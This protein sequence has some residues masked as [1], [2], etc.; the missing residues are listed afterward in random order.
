MP[1]QPPTEAYCVDIEH[2]VPTFVAV[3]IGPADPVTGDRT[4][5]WAPG[6]PSCSMVHTCYPASSG[7]PAVPP[8]P[9]V[10]GSPGTPGTPGSPANYLAGWTG[11]ARSVQ[12]FVGNCYYTF[13]V[14]YTVT[15]VVTGLNTRDDNAGFLEIP[16]GFRIQ[17]NTWA[18]IEHGQEKTNPKSRD[19]SGTTF[20][21]MQAGSHTYY[22]V[23]GAVVYTGDKVGD[24]DVFADASLFMGGDSITD[25]AFS[26]VLDVTLLGVTGGNDGVLP[27]NAGSFNRD[28]SKEGVLSNIVGFAVGGGANPGDAFQAIGYLSQLYTENWVDSFLPGLVGSFA[29]SNVPVVSVGILTGLVNFNER[30]VALLPRLIGYAEGNYKMPEYGINDVVLPSVVGFAYATGGNAG[31]HAGKLSKL[32][33]FATD[34]G[35]AF[36]EGVLT[37]AH[38]GFIIAEFNSNPGVLRNLVSNFNS[39]GDGDHA[40]RPTGTF[41][42]LWSME[43]TLAISRR[44]TGTFTWEPVVHVNFNPV[45]RI[46]GTMRGAETA[47]SYVAVQRRVSGSMAGAWGV[48]VSPEVVRPVRGHMHGQWGASCAVVR[49]ISLSGVFVSGETM[50]VK[51]KLK[52]K[53]VVADDEIVVYSPA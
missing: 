27:A 4:I 34:Q 3:F 14:P 22:V 29:L 33:G 38:D 48:S 1:A 49:H 19:F 44:M 2:C 47:R 25:A 15:G 30:E 5:L 52:R 32:V 7:T 24:G 36:S 11:G 23:D 37:G 26:D 50:A 12:S 21:V 20:G 16:R 13:A 28:W 17:N 31:G 35:A 41:Q 6:P 40:P 18:V 8:T 45:R 42:Q 53:A 51:A 39:G 46:A 10:P 9:P 43:A